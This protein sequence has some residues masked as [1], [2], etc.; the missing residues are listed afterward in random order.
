M[1]HR[2]QIAN[3]NPCAT[4][5]RL[6]QRCRMIRLQKLLAAAGLG[7]RRSVEQWIRDGRVTVAGRVAQLGDRA[8]PDDEVCL[9][10]R[11]LDLNPAQLTSRELLLYHKPVG[12][13][14]TRS[15][16]QGRP[17]VFER[18]AATGER[19]VDHGGPAGRQY[20][21]AAAFSRP[22]ASSPTG[23]CTPRVKSSANISCACVAGRNRGSSASCSKACSSTT[24][25]RG[26]TALRRRSATESLQTGSIRPSASFSTRAATARC[27]GSGRRSDWK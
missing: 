22:M 25:P 1:R 14:T 7:S 19:P 20:V 8:A 21:R 24:V 18:L 5:T 13:V 12:E 10:G 4:S 23:S 15:D 11:R 3:L 9:D 27:A 26:S 2:P 6:P 17:T 16:P